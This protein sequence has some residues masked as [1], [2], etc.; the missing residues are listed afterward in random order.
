MVQKPAYSR[1]LFFAFLTLY[2][3]GLAAL[4]FALD[5]GVRL[6][7]AGVLGLAF[8]LLQ[9]DIARQTIK[10][11]G[12]TRFIAICLLSGYLWLIVSGG[13]ALIYGAIPAGPIYDAMLHSIFLGFVFAMIFGHAPIIFPAVLGF[14]IEYHPRFYAPLAILHLSL[15]LRIVGE[16]AGF[17]WARLWGGL[18]NAVAV[19]AYLAMISPIAQKYLAASTTSEE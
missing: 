6:S 9:F 13:V 3:A 14:R 16:L 18:I 15:V 11:T 12:L 1:P 8:W 10:R 4:P 19:I 2:L 7:G 5:L 17:G